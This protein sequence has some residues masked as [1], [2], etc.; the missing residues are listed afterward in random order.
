M[1]LSNTIEN[2]HLV[3]LA[4]IEKERHYAT[5]SSPW[6]D[7]PYK[8]LWDMKPIPKG[9][10][11]LSLLQRWLKSHGVTSDTDGVGGGANA[12]RLADGAI[13]A[14]KFSMLTSDR[15]V[16]SFQ[17]IRDWPYR[18]AILFGLSPQRAHIWIVPREVL[19]AES[20][21]QHAEESR[22]VRIVAE[23]PPEWMSRYGGELD[24]A[25]TVLQEA[26]VW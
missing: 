6:M 3:A 22:V 25:A 26:K 18:A 4:G 2:Q 14:V 23:C 8:W 24:R 16:Y 17:Q 15:E 10:A 13:V 12:L 9:A 5:A 7:S 1:G 21:P 19:L 20:F 11:A